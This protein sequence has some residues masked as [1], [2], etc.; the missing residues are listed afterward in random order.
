MR[1]RLVLLYENMEPELTNL[2]PK[3]RCRALR[4]LYFM[5]LAVV[6]LIVLSGVAIVHGV[7]LLPSYLYLRNQVEGREASLARLTT[8]LAGTEEQ[9]ISMRVASLAA[10]SA[11]LAR[12]STVPKASAAVS[13]ILTLPRSGIR[14]TGF[15]FAPETEGA[16]MTVS[17]VAST[18]EALRRFEQLLAAEPYV[19]TADLPISAYAKESDIAFTITLTGPLMP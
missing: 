16:T 17:G 14:L 11:H 10:D 18:R 5:R 19:K 6:S 4:Q 13:A 12:L 1:P 3:D 8:A 7:L 9:G 2:L 15:S